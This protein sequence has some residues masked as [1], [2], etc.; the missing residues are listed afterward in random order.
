MRPPASGCR[1]APARS[2]PSAAAEN[3]AAAQLCNFAEPSREKTGKTNKSSAKLFCCYYCFCPFY[4]F[5]FFFFFSRSGS[6]FIFFFLILP[7]FSLSLF[8]CLSVGFYG[9]LTVLFLSL[10]FILPFLSLSSFAFYLTFPSLPTGRAPP[11]PRRPLRDARSRAAAASHAC[12][13]FLPPPHE[14]PAVS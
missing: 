12:P 8:P 2:L 9:F 11:F 13:R 1:S 5:I 10:F 7:S 6:G 4:R 14:L 3:C